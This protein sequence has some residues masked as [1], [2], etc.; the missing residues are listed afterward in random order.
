MIIILF[1]KPDDY[2]IFLPLCKLSYIIYPLMDR[3]DKTVISCKERSKTIRKRHGEK[4][5]E[6]CTVAH[7]I[8]DLLNFILLSC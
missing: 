7:K 8:I 5:K 1:P 4:N 2:L 6:R 3:T